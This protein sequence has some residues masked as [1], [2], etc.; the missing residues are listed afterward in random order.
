MRCLICNR[1]SDSFIDERS[2][3]DYFECD[4]CQFIMKSKDNF[5]DFGEQK[6]RYDLH[7]NSEDNI[8][9]RDYFNRLINFIEDDIRE[10]KSALDFGCGATS[11]LAKIVEERGIEADFY[12]PIY[13]PEEDYNKKYDLILS[14]EVFEHLHNP[15]EVFK[16]LVDRLNPNGYLVIQTAFHPR[17]RDKFLNWYY[18]L[19]PTHII[20]FSPRT[21]QELSNLFGLEIIK[22][23]N[24]EMIVMRRI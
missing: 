4:S 19:D 15:K 1:E 10:V 24:R 18:R 23:N 14:V 5:V 3:I 12:D 22:D 21:F 17:D 2:G 11:L 13:Y 16:T 6:I 20:F 8:G 9:Y 7:Q